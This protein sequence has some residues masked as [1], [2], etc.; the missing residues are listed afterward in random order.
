MPTGYPKALRFIED[1]VEKNLL[2]ESTIISSKFSFRVAHAGTYRTAEG[3]YGSD[4]EQILADLLGASSYAPYLDYWR[5]VGYDELMIQRHVDALQNPKFLPHVL[6]TDGSFELSSNPEPYALKHGLVPGQDTIGQLAADWWNNLAIELNDFMRDVIKLRN[7]VDVYDFDTLKKRGYP[8]FEPSYVTG[9]FL[10]DEALLAFSKSLATQIDHFLLK[11]A[12][13]DPDE[14]FVFTSYDELDTSLLNDTNGA[15]GGAGITVYVGYV[16]DKSVEGGQMRTFYAYRSQ[17]YLLRSWGFQGT[18]QITSTSHY[19]KRPMGTSFPVTAAGN[20]KIATHQNYQKL[21][22]NAC[23]LAT[24]TVM[25]IIGETVSC[26]LNFVQFDFY[27]QV[28]TVT[29]FSLDQG[30]AA[31]DAG[32][33]WVTFVPTN[34]PSFGGSSGPNGFYNGHVQ[35]FGDRAMYSSL[36]GYAPLE[37]YPYSMTLPYVEGSGLPGEA[38]PYNLI[39]NNYFAVVWSR[40]VQNLRLF[41][42]LAQASVVDAEL[43]LEVSTNAIYTRTPMLYIKD[44][45][46]QLKELDP[47]KAV[48]VDKLVLDMSGYEDAIVAATFL[49]TGLPAPFEVLKNTRAYAIA[50]E[51]GEDIYNMAFTENATFKTAQNR[52]NALPAQSYWIRVWDDSITPLDLVGSSLQP[53]VDASGDYYVAQT[54]ADS[55]YHIVNISGAITIDIST[56]DAIS[57]IVAG[58]VAYDGDGILF[59]TQSVTL[60]AINDQLG[61]EFNMSDLI[62]GSDLSGGDWTSFSPD[63]FTDSKGFPRPELFTG[64]AAARMW[65]VYKGI[66]LSPLERIMKSLHDLNPYVV[67]GEV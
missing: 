6:S 30:I 4:K 31:P 43:L 45:A 55:V 58:L 21:S 46:L 38:I 32:I 24:S 14:C 50:M 56:M 47:S 62:L 29:T 27:R 36:P 61:T 13:I 19:V 20:V 49:G 22:L 25:E 8:F 67:I 53:Y 54:V 7:S 10:R 44:Y 16:F 35:L 9:S 52:I 2:D 66:D 12:G 5:S 15:C 63:V 59:N 57:L 26:T 23:G 39:S 40:H 41:P 60:S 51:I 1:S 3:L 48:E 42:S 17:N 37:V 33:P 64:D 34:A 65:M 28:K 18:G 11:K